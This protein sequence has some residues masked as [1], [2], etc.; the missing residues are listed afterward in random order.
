MLRVS[1][2]ERKV[3]IPI[4]SLAAKT[5]FSFSLFAN[6]VHTYTSCI[7]QDRDSNKVLTMNVRATRTVFK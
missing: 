2:K 5:Q 1:R 3:H 4:S 6:C 7:H